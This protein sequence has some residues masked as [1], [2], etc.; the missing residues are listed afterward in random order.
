MDDFNAVFDGKIGW[1]INGEGDK[2]NEGLS[3][4]YSA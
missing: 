2:C 4:V 1:K 3:I